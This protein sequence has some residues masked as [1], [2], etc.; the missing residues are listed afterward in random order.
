VNFEGSEVAKRESGSAAQLV[1]L[2]SG[3]VISVALGVV[4][5]V[6]T[7]IPTALASFALILG[8]LLTL[9]VEATF[10][11]LREQQ[12]Q[13]EQGRFIALLESVPWLYRFLRDTAERVVEVQ[14]VY[15]SPFVLH[16][17]QKVSG[18]FAKGLDDLRGG[19]ILVPHDSDH[20]LVFWL[21]RHTK[22]TLRATDVWAA[23]HLHE[24]KSGGDEYQSLNLEAMERGVEVERIFIYAEWTG[25]LEDTVRKQAAAGIHTLRVREAILKAELRADMAI[26]DEI[27]GSEL[28]F[29]AL[30]E[31][32]DSYVTFSKQDVSHLLE[33][34][35]R[36][37]AKAE[38]WPEGNSL[39]AEK[40]RRRSR[41]RHPGT[42]RAAN[43][44]EP[45]QYL[46]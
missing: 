2:I 5:Y 46:K 22:S 19:R 37:K 36:I 44:A 38:V 16:L 18:D 10:R 11:R 17:L 32:V 14:R 23:A 39:S 13:T 33:K 43:N 6:R 42:L 35:N 15:D 26:W 41:D 9:Q 21:T 3:F 25:D 34:Y 7:D 12:T 24:G 27:Y 45:I 28:S 4:F 31:I 1:I 8:G 20:D 29:N 30:G 40:R